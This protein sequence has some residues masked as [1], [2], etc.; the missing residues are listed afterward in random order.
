MF[1]T[2][3]SALIGL[4]LTLSVLFVIIIW[5]KGIKTDGWR[6]FKSFDKY[7]IFVHLFVL[8]MPFQIVLIGF[9]KSVD[10]ISNVFK[11]YYKN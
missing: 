1:L 10:E 6:F 9:L 8:L 11:K 5:F 3:F 2:V 7:M 4:H